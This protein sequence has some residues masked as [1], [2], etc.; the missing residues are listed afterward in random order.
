MKNLSMKEFLVRHKLNSYKTPYLLFAVFANK[1]R[2]SRYNVKWRVAFI[3]I[4]GWK[5][6]V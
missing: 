1:R 2:I 3:K 6:A 4:F 5:W